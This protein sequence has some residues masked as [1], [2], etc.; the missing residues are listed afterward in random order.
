MILAPLS[1]LRIWSGC[2][3][4]C[5]LAA[6]APIGLLVWES[7]Y[8]A[9]VALNKTKQDGKRKALFPSLGQTI[10]LTTILSFTFHTTVRG[11]EYTT[12]EHVCFHLR[13]KASQTYEFKLQP[14]MDVPNLLCDPLRRPTA[15]ALLPDQLCHQPWEGALLSFWRHHYSWGEA[16]DSH[17]SSNRWSLD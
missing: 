6:S 16:G 2:E 4:W 5:R 9:S 15:R 3:L 1:G 12:G 7:P 11:H 13:L 10:T 8:A 14:W 17:V